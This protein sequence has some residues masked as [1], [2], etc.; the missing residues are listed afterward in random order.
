MTNELVSVCRVQG[1]D[2][3]GW[4]Y[5]LDSRHVATSATAVREQTAVKVDVNGTILGAQVASVDLVADLAL[6][7][8]D[9]AA[10]SV[11]S[12]T[13]TDVPPRWARVRLPANN[14]ELTVL[15]RNANRTPDGYAAVLFS[16][17]INSGSL[18][19]ASTLAGLPVV[20]GNTVV[21]QIMG[22]PP[23]E[24]PGP[25]S[26]GLLFVASPQG[27]EALYEGT[28]SWTT[29]RP[30]DQ[31]QDPSTVQT[32]LVDR[33]SRQVRSMETRGWSAR[34][35]DAVMALVET[36]NSLGLFGQP[37]PLLP[38]S[39]ILLGL[40][41]P[42]LAVAALEHAGNSD[43]VLQQRGLAYARAGE[44]ERARQILESLYATNPDDP[45]TA[46]ILAGILRR[47][48][49]EGSRREARRIYNENW[50]KT[51]NT[52]TGINAAAL[53]LV[54]GDADE[55]TSI[56]K[57]VLQK[58]EQSNPDERNAWEWATVGEAYL[59]LNDLERAREGYRNAAELAPQR[60]HDLG[61]ML[62]QARQ[63]LALHGLP[64][65]SLDDALPVPQVIAYAGHM[66]DTPNSKYP[67]R[68]PRTS[69]GAVR[70][71]I[72]EKLQTIGKVHAVGSAANG[73]DLLFLEAIIESG[74]TAQVILPF[75]QGHFE[76]IS[77]G[78]RDLRDFR[79][80]V[81]HPNVTLVDPGID[82]PADN[83]QREQ[84]YEAV[85]R[86]IYR[87]ADA[88]AQRLGQTPVPI[89]VWDRK[90]HGHGAYG[91]AF[92]VK[93]WQDE[94]GRSVE[95]ID[96]PKVAGAE[97]GTA[98]D[99]KKGSGRSWPAIV[100]LAAAGAVG[101]AVFF[102]LQNDDDQPAPPPPPPPSRTEIV[103]KPTAVPPASIPEGYDPKQ[104]AGLF[105]G[106][107]DFGD[108]IS[109]VEYAIDDAVDLAH[110][111]AM[112]L[113]WIPPANVELAVTGEP[114]K[115]VSKR[116]L[117]A[118]RN[119]GAHVI[120][121]TQANLLDAVARTQSRTGAQGLS[122]LSISSHGFTNK[123]AALSG[124][125]YFVFTADTSYRSRYETALSLR[126]LLEKIE[127]G[128]HHPKTGV[129]R[130]LPN[131]GRQHQTQ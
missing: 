19:P 65:D 90:V 78:D 66:L 39:E 123:E 15:R 91:T 10:D 11:E 105:I 86:K 85:S 64:V 51:G 72:R 30:E 23:R 131:R 33:F 95:V 3:R 8:L 40:N 93:L 17:Q 12:P 75:K 36:W 6:L 35:G 118:L 109:P 20:W 112:E 110:A 41:Q 57:A 69:M 130:H 32:Q 103:V 126:R 116:R 49:D 34:T 60:I 111:F 129:D 25:E 104:S 58:L 67:P 81:R 48:G 82:A 2:V 124:A 1:R 44:T 24:A 77:V 73:A 31:T 70:N 76:Q 101:A 26:F 21:G 122:M 52:Y 92:A 38:A 84:L 42:Q 56:A 114:E 100:G 9:N 102:G 115:A 106:I 61:V 98:G 83:D 50:N 55:A 14:I 79:R 117:T 62:G 128:Q 47:R 22:R 27:V 108:G 37:G 88:F 29:A 28:L 71:A 120:G 119:A 53:A 127:K 7:V 113:R 87:D 13:F 16:A 4:G 18:E 54:F 59:I 94:L 5:L 125:G 68:F 121:A 45:E 99:S 107:R 63:H 43:Q 74:G 46:G 89:V 96:L 97:K 80:L